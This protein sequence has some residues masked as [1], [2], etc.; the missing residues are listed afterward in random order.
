LVDT[1]GVISIPQEYYGE[2]IKVGSMVVTN[3]VQKQQPM[4]VIQI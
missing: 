4:M 2:G 3:M 1:I